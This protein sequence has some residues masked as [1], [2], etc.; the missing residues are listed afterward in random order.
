MESIEKRIEIAGQKWMQA[1]SA[2]DTGDFQ[3]AYNRYTVA[4]DIIMD[5]ARLHQRAHEYLRRINWKMGNYGE[6]VT[7]WMLHLFAPL[8]VFELVSCLSKNGTFGSLI[9]KRTAP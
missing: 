2:E 6:L 3:L 4:H 1:K 9:C 8:G 7:D 5:C